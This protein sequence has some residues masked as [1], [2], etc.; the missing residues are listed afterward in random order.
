MPESCYFYCEIFAT[1]KIVSIIDS[2]R[3]TKEEGLD[4]EGN[5]RKAGV[6]GGGPGHERRIPRQ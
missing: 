2:E 1:C 6:R 4:S 3:N 5:F